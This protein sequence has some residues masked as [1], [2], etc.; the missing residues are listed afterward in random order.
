MVVSDGQYYQQAM[1]GSQLSEKIEKNE[2]RN[3]CVIRVK[4]SVTNVIQNRR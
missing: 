1:I 2:V 3:M 4:D